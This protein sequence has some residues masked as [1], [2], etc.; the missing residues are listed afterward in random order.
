MVKIENMKSKA[1]KFG[2]SLRPYLQMIK[3]H[4][5]RCHKKSLN[6]C[7]KSLALSFASMFLEYD[8]S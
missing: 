2:H 6:G 3:L 1:N 5:I 7:G 8:Q 4:N